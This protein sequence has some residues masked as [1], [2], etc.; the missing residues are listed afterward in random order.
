[1][2]VLQYSIGVDGES[3]RDCAN[4]EQGRHGAHETT[5]ATVLRPGHLVFHYELLPFLLVIVEVH[6]Q[7]QQWLPL[8]F[9]GYFPNV[10]QCFPARLAPSSPKVEE[11]DFSLQLIHRNPLT[12]HCGD[13]KAWRHPGPRQLG[14]TE[15]AQGSLSHRIIGGYHLNHLLK[16]RFGGIVLLEERQDPSIE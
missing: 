10:R 13:R 1:M 11:H 9:L 8:E 4:S 15:V 5:V 14:F 2:L 3:L 16:A 12:I 6:A 7:H